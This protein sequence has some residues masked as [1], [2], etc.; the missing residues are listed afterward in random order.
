MNLF[1]IMVLACALAD[2]PI[3]KIDSVRQRLNSSQSSEST[4]P[5]AETSDTPS[6][7]NNQ[8]GNQTS[9][10]AG[11]G[12]Y[13]EALARLTCAVALAP[14]VLPMETLDD[15]GGSDFLF[16]RYPYAWHDDQHY[17]PALVF[18]ETPAARSWQTLAAIEAGTD[19][20]GLRRYAI[21]ASVDTASRW[22]MQVSWA[23]YEERIA[24]LGFNDRIDVANALLTYRFAQSACVQFHAGLGTRL[25][26]DRDQTHVGF[27]SLYAFSWYP[28]KPVVVQS[29]LHLGYV[30]Q[31][32]MQWRVTAG[33]TK[34]RFEAYVGYDMLAVRDAPL[35]GLVTGLAIRF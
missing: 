19:F 12:D 26:S 5:S 13:C 2:E 3:G 22:G 33:V 28:C 4:N 25:F 30:D 34:D 6:C 23:H 27:D 29:E 15:E 24:R 32:V 20:D 7:T 18:A 8:S 9:S 21:R 17:M 14:F 31:I 35:Q 11:S 16:S 10:S 1:T